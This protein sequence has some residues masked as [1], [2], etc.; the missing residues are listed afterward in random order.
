MVSRSTAAGAE[1]RQRLLAAAAVEFAERGYDGAKVD[2]IATRA[3][4]NKAML[5]YHFDDKAALY[6]EVLID[7]FRGVAASVATA[8]RSGAPDTQIR[9]FV[10]AVAA[11]TA[12]RPYFPVMWLREIA[13][14]GRHLDGDVIAELGRVLGTLGTIISAGIKAGQFRAA[15]PLIIQMGIVAPLLVFS[16]SAHARARFAKALPGSLA[17]PEPQ[18]LLA[19]VEAATLAALRTD[20]V[21]SDPPARRAR[22]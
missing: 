17:A 21:S 14:G 6:R 11:E 22:R 4:L 3:R 2:R 9:A 16:A 12:S 10:R 15:H 7:V 18:A 13:D 1:S 19:H 8:T 20:H 5:Y